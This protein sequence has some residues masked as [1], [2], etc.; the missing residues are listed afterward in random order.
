MSTPVH[1]VAGFLG[2]GKT[3]LL[4]R[5][6][7]ARQSHEKCAVVVND[8][9]EAQ[10]DRQLLGAAVGVRDISG[11][12]MCC[13]A[14]ENLVPSLAAILDELKPDRIFIEPSGLGRPQDILDMIGRSGIKN[15]LAIQPVL[16]LVDPMMLTHP[17]PLLLEQLEAADILVASRCDRAGASELAAF[18]ELAATLWPA[19]LFVLHSLYGQV[20]E[21]VW[22]WP[23][24][25]G[26]RLKVPTRKTTP[27]TEG[28]SAYSM[29]YPATVCFDWIRLHKLLQSCVSLIRFKGLIHSDAGWMRL[30]AAGGQFQVRGSPWRQDSR[31][32]AIFQGEVPEFFEEQLKACLQLAPAAIGP[33]LVLVDIEGGGLE[34]GIEGLSALPGQVGDVGTLVAGREGEGVFFREL[35]ALIGAASTSR[36]VV[37]AS[38]GM[39]SSPTTLAE[40]GDA[41]LVYRNQGQPLLEKQGG[42]FRLLSPA[43][44][45]CGNIKGVVRVRILPG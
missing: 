14:P 21:K 17:H 6:L 5:E 43:G 37:S 39:V 3:T 15:Q 10:L 8:F 28:F 32:D 45:K 30:D 40:T 44:S 26:L 2:A 19:P 29:V 41:V 20:P 36:Y 9:G 24:D 4:R 16:V 12:C 33:K 25:T 1:L 42:P 18:D 34:L 27:S 23:P 38:D 7:A 31:L 35:L 11:G 13:T 22:S